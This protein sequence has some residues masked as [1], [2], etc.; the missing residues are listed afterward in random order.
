MDEIVLVFKLNLL[1]QDCMCCKEIG[2][3]GNCYNHQP[4]CDVHSPP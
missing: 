1:E 3:K 2:P 4:E